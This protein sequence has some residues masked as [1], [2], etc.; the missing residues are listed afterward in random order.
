[1]NEYYGLRSTGLQQ[2]P[3]NRYYVLGWFKED[4]VV[5]ELVWARN[6]E[7][8]KIRAFK[9]SKLTNSNIFKSD[10]TYS[11]RLKK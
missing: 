9:Q 3:V 11:V 10:L 4:L 6:R 5:N 7:E 2:N 1:M 8:A